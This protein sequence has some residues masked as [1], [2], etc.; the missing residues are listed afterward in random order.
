MRPAPRHRE[1]R[2]LDVTSYVI[3]LARWPVALVPGAALSFTDGRCAEAVGQPHVVPGFQ[4]SSVRSRSRRS[5][6]GPARPDE[7]AD[8]CDP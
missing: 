6:S 8:R 7:M 3:L 2:L 5:D 4:V 1:R